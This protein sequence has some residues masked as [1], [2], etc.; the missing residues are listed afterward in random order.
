MDVRPEVWTATTASSNEA[1]GSVK[2]WEAGCNGY[3]R[4]PSGLVVTQ[5]PYSMSEFQRRTE[6]VDGGDYRSGRRSD[7]RA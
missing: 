6:R 5:W 3:Y 7:A 4:S 1:I 2:V